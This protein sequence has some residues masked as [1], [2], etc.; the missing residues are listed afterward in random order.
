VYFSKNNIQGDQIKNTAI[1]MVCST[2]GGE[3]YTGFWWGNLTEGDHLEESGVGG[4]IILKCI[5]EEWDGGAWTES[6]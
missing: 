1:G 4:R 3:V 5:I 2:Y 6:I